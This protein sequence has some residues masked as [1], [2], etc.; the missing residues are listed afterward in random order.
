MA[1]QHEF[2]DVVHPRVVQAKHYW[3]RSCL[4]AQILKICPA[5]VTEGSS[6]YRAHHS[7]QGVTQDLTEPCDMPLLPILFSV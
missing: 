5:L 2:W 6:D 7:A 1:K 3:Y 4:T